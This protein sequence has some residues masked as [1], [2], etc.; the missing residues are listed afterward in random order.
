[1]GGEISYFRLFYNLFNVYIA[2]FF[3]IILVGLLEIIPREIE[4]LELEACLG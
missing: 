1:M 2:V 4:S 3:I